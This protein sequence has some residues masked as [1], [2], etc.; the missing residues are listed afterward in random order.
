M[1]K[2]LRSFQWIFQHYIDRI[3]KSCGLAVY[4]LYFF[5]NSNIPKVLLL[6]LYWI[7]F[8][9]LNYIISF[10]SLFFF[11]PNDF[12]MRGDCL[13]CL[14]SWNFYHHCLNFLFIINYRN[15][16]SYSVFE[17]IRLVF[18]FHLFCFVIVNWF[19]INH[20]GG[21]MVSVLPSSVVGMGLS[22]DLVNPKTIKLVFVSSPL[23]TQH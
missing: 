22:P 11:M 13:F 12:R 15:C 20:I 9:L 18:P 5:N 19:V 21:V 8:R 16:V 10:H 1:Y 14:Y 7:Y 23:N 17:M 3:K 6:F 4:I 2:N